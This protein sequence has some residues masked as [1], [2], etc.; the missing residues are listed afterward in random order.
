M[1]SLKI[2]SLKNFMNHLLAGDT[3]D[4]FLLEEA[5]ITTANTYHIDGHM[6]KSFFSEEELENENVCAYDFA[7]WKDIKGL[8]FQLIKGKRTPL[9]FK[10]VLLLLPSY[11][12]QILNKENLNID[13]SLLK[14]LVLTIKYDGNQAILTTGSAYHSFLLSHEPDKIWD[15]NLLHYLNKKGIDYELL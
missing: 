9:S 5:T 3:F 15:T 6:E 2:N 1:L 10:F 7:L 14:S 13:I 11:M 4:I 8:C 12:E